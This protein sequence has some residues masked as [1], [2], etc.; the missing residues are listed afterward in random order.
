MTQI[1][2][3]KFTY[4]DVA[5]GDDQC[6]ET[7]IAEHYMNLVCYTC[8]TKFNQE[9]QISNDLLLLGGRKVNNVSGVKTDNCAP[10]GD[11]Y[12]RTG[13]REDGL[14]DKHRIEWRCL[15]PEHLDLTQHIGGR[16]AAKEKEEAAKG[17]EKPV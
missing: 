2:L 15:R 5:K 13:H 3:Y 9:L 6:N 1:S 7:T 8:K 10:S 17:R 4:N 16:E 12:Y 14:A 11:R